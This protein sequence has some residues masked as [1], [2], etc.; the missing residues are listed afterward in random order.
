MP[1][2]RVYTNL[3]ASTFTKEKVEAAS[4]MFSASIKKP[5]KWICVHF[6]PDQIMM[7]A[8]SSDPCAQGNR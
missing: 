5:E 4:K 7:F 3:P 1:L 2:L 6:I 8:G